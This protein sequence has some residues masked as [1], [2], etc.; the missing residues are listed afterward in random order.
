MGEEEMTFEEFNKH[1]DESHDEGC[2]MC[3]SYHHYD[4]LDEPTRK[5][6]Y[7][8][9]IGKFEEC[10]QEVASEL[11]RLEKEPINDNIYFL[12]GQTEIALVEGI[13]PEP[14]LRDR[15]LVQ[16]ARR[17]NE[18]IHKK[19][20]AAWVAVRAYG[21]F[22]DNDP[23]LLFSFL[24]ECEKADWLDLDVWQVALQ[25]I[26]PNIPSRER[27]MVGQDSICLSYMKRK[28]HDY[29]LKAIALGNDVKPSVIATNGIKAMASLQ[30]PR[31][32][33]TMDKFTD[34]SF[35][36]DKMIADD[37]DHKIAYLTKIGDTA[38]IPTLEQLKSKCKN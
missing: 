3:F 28:V 18:M 26:T 10:L 8:N 30:D 19:M 35:V 20:P 36:L 38:F 4:H 15:I 29:T 23:I 33:E 34:R 25:C 17:A 27:K 7:F 2:G 37:V 1:I 13:K 9:F 31:V 5:V 22:P 11:E 24:E 16:L 32:L 6:A 12:L 14:E 21:W